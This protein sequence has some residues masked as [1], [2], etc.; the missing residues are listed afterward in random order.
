MKGVLEA[1]AFMFD[2]EKVKIDTS[3]HNAAR[4]SGSTAPRPAR[5]TTCQSARTADPKH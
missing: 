4:M 2:D 5:S 1:L 3:V